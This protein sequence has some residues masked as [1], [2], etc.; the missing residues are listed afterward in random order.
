[1]Q[2]NN[3]YPWYG[4]NAIVK[5]IKTSQSESFDFDRRNKNKLRIE[6]RNSNWKMYIIF[7]TQHG[8]LIEL[9]IFRWRLMTQQNRWKSNLWKK[10]LEILT[11][12]PGLPGWEQL[13]LSQMEKKSLHRYVRGFCLSGKITQSLQATAPVKQLTRQG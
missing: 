10:V 2:E 8:K 5:W 12:H 1:M 11:K 7:T 3:I 9:N 13:R 4:S 6:L